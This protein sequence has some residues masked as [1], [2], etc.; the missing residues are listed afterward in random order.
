MK[1]FEIELWAQRVITRLLSGGLKEDSLVELKAKWPEPR[2]N[3]RQLGGHANA[4]KGAAIL[5]IIGFDEQKG[6]VGALDTEV[7]DWFNQVRSEFDDGVCPALLGAVAFERNSINLVAMAF[8]TERAPYVI[9]NPARGTD[10]SGPFSLETPWRDASGTRSAGR[11]ELL[12]LI[13]STSRAS[14][15]EVLAAT[16]FATLVFR[17]NHT[18]RASPNTPTEQRAIKWYLEAQLY[19]THPSEG[20]ITI[21]FHKI[22]VTVTETTLG[23]VLSL[24][25]LKF[26]VATRYEGNR[27]IADSSAI[28]VSATQIVLSGSG[29]VQMIA[30]TLDEI[31]YGPRLTGNV[32]FHGEFHVAGIVPPMTFEATMT[33]EEPPAKDERIGLW[34]I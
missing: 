33:S 25:N 4:A 28:T 2:W 29:S 32:E 1:L 10:K 12:S 6:L 24:D 17:N 31:E 5:W 20:T 9:R 34:R 21:P 16:L 30:T 18:V 27:A 22:S 13:E 8:S 11:M 7:G 15:I 26:D 14:S 19:F 23:R 3:A